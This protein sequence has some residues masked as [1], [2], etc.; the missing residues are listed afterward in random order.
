MSPS[1]FNGGVPVDVRE[2]TEAEPVVV[3]HRGVG[4]SVHVDCT[5]LC[6]VHFAHPRVQ[7]VVRDTAPERGLLASL[8]RAEVST[9]IFSGCLSVTEKYFLGSF[10]FIFLQPQF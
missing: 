7:F 3:V 2:L 1:V 4:E 10:S 6:M 5:G 8:K 9:R